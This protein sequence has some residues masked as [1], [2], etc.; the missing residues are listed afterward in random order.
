MQAKKK[1]E[2]RFQESPQNVSIHAIALDCA[3]AV[4]LMLADALTR[5]DLII[6][7]RDSLARGMHRP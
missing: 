6:D 2:Y 4:T 5:F 3:A 7:D 1:T